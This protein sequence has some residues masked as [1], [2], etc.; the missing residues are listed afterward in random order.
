[1]RA[2]GAHTHACVSVSEDYHGVRAFMH[3]LSGPSASRKADSSRAHE[4][5]AS[6]SCA[7]HLYSARHAETSNRRGFTD[8]FSASLQL[9]YGS[10]CPPRVSVLTPQRCTV[11]SKKFF[12]HFQK[13]KFNFCPKTFWRIER[14]NGPPYNDPLSTTYVYCWDQ[15]YMSTYTICPLMKSSVIRTRL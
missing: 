4:F 11:A 2:Q 8:V 3:M 6:M 5:C 13:K 15:E 14:V 7:W 1:V 9:S 12:E 10:T